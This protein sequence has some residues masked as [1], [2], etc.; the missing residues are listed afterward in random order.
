MFRVTIPEWESGVKGESLGD[1]CVRLDK[2]RFNTEG[3]EERGEHGGRER[4]GK[5]KNWKRI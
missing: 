1:F 2:K 3:T 4:E 5:S